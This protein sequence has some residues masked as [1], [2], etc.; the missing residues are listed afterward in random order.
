MT[1]FR[2][3]PTTNRF[4][5]LDKIKGFDWILAFFD[6]IGTGGHEVVLT[7]LQDLGGVHCSRISTNNRIVRINFLGKILKFLC[8]DEDNYQGKLVRY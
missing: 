6:V 8:N 3:V 7:T 4:D 5:W 2:Q 1:H